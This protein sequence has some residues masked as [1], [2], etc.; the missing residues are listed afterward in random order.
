MIEERPATELVDQ[1]R[2]EQR[3]RW[4]DSDRVPVEDLLGQHPLLL[5]DTERALELVYGEVLLSEEL[6]E[7]PELE[8]YTRRFPALAERLVA[9][10]DVHRALESGRL[11]DLTAADTPVGRTAWDGDPIPAGPRPVLAGYEILDELGRGGMGVVYRA[12]HV[13]LNR[14]VALKMILAGSHAGPV[15]VSRFRAEAEAVARIQHPN[16]VQIFDVG[17]QD[18]RPFFSLELIEGGSL[19]QY[20]DG[21]PQPPERAVGWVRTLAGA[22]EAAH[23]AGIIHRDLKPSNI[24]LANDGT[25][26]ITDFGLAKTL[27]ADVG[28]TR[29]DSVMG[30]PSYMA[31]EQAE[32][33]S[34]Q[35]GPAADIY[36]LGAILYDLLTGRPPFK[37]ATALE[38]LQQVKAIEPLPPGRL[39]PGLPRDLETICLKCLEKEPSRRYATAGALA[40]ELDRFLRHE[41]ILARPIGRLERTARWCRHNP[42]LAGCIG[43]VAVLMLVLTAGSISA[44]VRLRAQRDVAEGHA[45]RAERAENDATEKLWSADL[46]VAQAGRWSG[47]I[48]RRFEGLGAL[49]QAAALDTFPERRRELRDEAIACMALLD[50]RAS[51]R[52]EEGRSKNTAGALNVDPK[53]DRFVRVDPD[54]MLRLRRASDGA[55][56][57]P[58]SIPKAREYWVRFSPDGRYL[59]V[60]YD[61]LERKPANCQVWDL[62]RGELITALTSYLTAYDFSPDGQQMAIARM[63]GSVSFY[64]LPSTKLAGRW[65]AGATVRPIAFH[66]NGTQFAVVEHHGSDIRICDRK[67]GRVLQT[68]VNPNSVEQLAWRRDGR[69]LAASCG[70]KVQIWDMDSS[71]LL[72]VLDGHQSA[73]IGFSFNDAGDL[74]ATSSWDATTMIWDPVSGRSHIRLPGT[75]FGWGPDD[76]SLLIALDSRVISYELEHGAEC[77]TLSHGLVGNRTP[78]LKGG[79][80]TVDFSPDSRLLASA[81]VDGVRIYRPTDGVE[82]GHLAIGFT[83]SALFEPAGGLLTYNSTLGLARWPARQ[84]TAGAVVF[85]PPENLPLPPNQIDDGRYLAIDREGGRLLATDWGNDQAV[86]IATA[87][88]R[89]PA[90]LMPHFHINH[91]ALSPDGRWAATGT[92]KGSGVKIWD[93]ARGSLAKEWPSGEASVGFSPDGR[94][95]VTCHGDAYRF[96]HVGSWQ[97]GPVIPHGSTTSRG[98]MAFRPDSRV[99]AIVKS[100]MHQPVVQLIDPTTGE[101]I[102]IL[103]APDANPIISRLCFSP[104]GRQLAAATESHRI[105][106]WDLHKIRERLVT[107]GLGQSFP[108]DQTSELDWQQAD[109]Q[110]HQSV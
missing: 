52:W 69:L 21:L 39:Q 108:A 96:Y 47:R 45:A 22:V 64:D 32:G 83:E 50:L 74:L 15:Q 17:V 77:R 35:V 75:F 18:G 78:P 89:Q 8:E 25:L 65:E 33:R 27:G 99:M 44:A 54:G 80:W 43:L 19:A 110:S 7:G 94:W 73:G 9:L 93:T 23:V 106:L 30:S 55:E 58:L 5:A 71:A 26:K 38:T 29:T 13:G 34:R 95:F 68:L 87:Q 41:P 61:V 107:M 20:T 101:E 105:Q 84:E 24:L 63:G 14:Q 37:G 42:A 82:I 10:F 2:A 11:L 49:K 81:G 102:A 100:V 103:Q 1:L 104:D 46:A 67:T 85:G 53:H 12:R 28:V 59:V 88:P 36:A 109:R 92:W 86:L 3:R 56:L 4:M 60:E 31:P 76:R 90:V 72:S 6:G 51:T 40:D 79:P 66:P 62:D 16:I 97:P 98:P 91:V 57:L 70:T 48:G